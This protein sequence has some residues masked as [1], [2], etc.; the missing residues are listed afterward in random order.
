M[1][2]TPKL[3]FKRETV[4][5]LTSDQ[6]TRVAGGQLPTQPYSDYPSSHPYFCCHGAPT[7]G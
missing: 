1:K 7:T 2:K 6:L 3:T 4:Q 5:T